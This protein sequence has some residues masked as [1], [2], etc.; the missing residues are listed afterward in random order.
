MGKIVKYDRKRM[1]RLLLLLPLSVL[2]MLVVL[3]FIERSR[4]IDKKFSVGYEGPMKFVPEVRILDERDFGE[5]DDFTEKYK[6]MVSRKVV[7]DE[8]SRERRTERKDSEEAEKELSL[9]DE[10]QFD[11]ERFFRTYTSRA[12]IPYSREYVIEEMVEP[13][14][15]ADALENGIEGYVIVEVQVSPS[16]KVHSAHARKVFGAESFEKASLDAV[17]RFRFKPKLK[18]GK[19]VTFWVSFL[20]R[21]TFNAR[22]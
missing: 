14:Y 15:P 20:I 6:P 22:R 5:E 9:P 1:K 19:P 3:F 13:E 11:S 8:E 2:I 18:N 10:I 12:E 21:F 16:G 7:T 4:I 17:R